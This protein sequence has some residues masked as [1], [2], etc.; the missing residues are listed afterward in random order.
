M[1]EFVRYGG[2]SSAGRAPHCGC[3]C[4]GFEPHHPPQKMFA[5]GENARRFFLASPQNYY[6]TGK[7]SIKNHSIVSIWWL[8][9][10]PKTLPAA[11]A[12][13]LVAGAVSYYENVFR[14]DVFIVALVGALLLQIGA[15]LANDVFDYYKGADTQERLGPLRVT[16]AGLLTPKQVIL[17]IVI[18]FS[19]AAISGSYLVAIGGWPILI[20]GVSAILAALAYTGGPLPYG[21]FG[22]GEVFVFIFFGLAAVG[23]TYYAMAKT[24][25]PL[26]IMSAIPI[27]LL[28]TAILVVNNLRD[29]HT[30]RLA[31]KRT[32]AVRFGERFTRLEYLLLVVLAYLICLTLIVVKVAPVWLVLVCISIPLSIMQTNIVLNQS[33]KELNR[34]LA[35]T[36]QLALVFAIFYSLGLF[37]PNLF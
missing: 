2:C 29:I 7:N 30:D 1:I 36:S 26:A 17:G 4:R 33:G 12:P 13:V 35:G 32:L 14:G 22:L 5:P 28:I 23:G 3:G 31:E 10:R 9:A 34:A 16:Q 6:M 11:S 21:Y 27:G 8:A 19:L 20:I 37:L 24:L 15:N 18:C 25:T